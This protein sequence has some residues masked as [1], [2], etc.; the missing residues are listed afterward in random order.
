MKRSKNYEFEFWGS[1]NDFYGIRAIKS[2]DALPI[3]AL[4]VA[5]SGRGYKI[6]GYSQLLLSPKYTAYIIIGNPNIAATW[7]IASL[8]RLLGKQVFFWTHGWLRRESLPKRVIRNI[9]YRL[10]NAILVY[11]NRSK[12][13][14]IKEGYPESRIHVIYNSLDYKKATVIYNKLK[15]GAGVNNTKQLFANPDLPLLVCSAR[16]TD[17]CRHDILI[18]A[19]HALAKMGRPVNILLIGDGPE[20]S[21]IKALAN[22]MAV[23]LIFF[24]ECYDEEIVG[25]LIFDSD[26]TVTAGKAGLTAIHSLSYGTPVF[27]HSNLDDQMPESETIIPGISGDLFEQ[28]DFND[29]A[30]KLLNWLTKNTDR[31]LV[32]NSCRTVIEQTWTP[33]VQIQRLEA[34]IRLHV[35]D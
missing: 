18:S 13:I 29:L 30:E 27:S 12:S 14:G 1:E 8:A 22:E 16:L 25:R 23:P 28:N 10:A 24:G 34:A 2:S 3:N 15:Q 19:A 5:A 32:R 31:Q 9:Y 21:K 11:G 7:I 35:R 4:R 17:L 26:L 33:E 20:K 6:T